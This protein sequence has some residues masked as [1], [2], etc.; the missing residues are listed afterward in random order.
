MNPTGLVQSLLGLI[1]AGNLKQF[2][3][4]AEKTE[5]A[6][7][8]DVLAS[9]D[10]QERLAVVKQLPPR[11]SGRALIEMA[12]ETQAEET[13]VALEPRRLGDRRGAAGRRAD[14]W[15]VGSTRRINSESSRRSRTG[16][17]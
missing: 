13:L 11:L 14:I 3:A 6:D 17:M 15:S 12:D 10:N 7:L 4:R 8:G 1:R 5:P 2:L 9:L 16:R